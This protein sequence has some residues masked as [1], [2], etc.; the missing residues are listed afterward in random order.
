[1]SH[2]GRLIQKGNTDLG[3][4]TPNLKTPAAIKTSDLG[5]ISSSALNC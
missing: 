1:M 5:S 2:T 3:I 4:G